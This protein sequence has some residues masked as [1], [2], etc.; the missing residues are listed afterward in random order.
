MRFYFLVISIA[1]LYAVFADH[2]SHDKDGNHKDH[3]HKGHGDHHHHDHHHGKEKHHHHH[4]NHSEES[5]ACHKLSPFNSK[6]AFNLFRQVAAEHPSENIFFSPVS[7]ST[8]FA[9]LSLGAKGATLS[10]IL[11]G[12]SFNASE[13][14]E[15]EIH[16]GFQ[17]LLHM[18]NDPHSEL[19]LES[20]NALFV[21]DDFKPLQKFL[22]DVKKFYESE[23]FST[24][25]KNEEE[26]KKLINDYVEKKTHGKIAELLKSVNPQSVLLLIN[27]IYFRGKW[28]KPFEV[29]FTKDGDFHVDN[30]TVVT[31]PMMS[32][33]GRF[34]VAYDKEHGCTVVE[35]PYKGNAT[36][37]FI[38]PDEGKL[39]QVEEALNKP[40][41]KSWKKLFH[42][43]SIDLKIPKFSIS[44]TLDLK[45]ELTK[46]GV[47]D[48]FS[49]RSDL[50][51]IVESPP[52]KVS[53]A[54]HKAVLSIDEKGTEAA[55]TT[56]IEIMPM[57]LPMRYSFDR[58][59]LVVIYDLETRN[60]LFL[61]RIV[62]PNK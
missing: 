30:E 43:Q 5:M 23:A 54:I 3:D 53:K 41:I 29:E 1:L 24:D 58:P 46:M 26:A 50:S 15:E 33:N 28:E 4:H 36:S 19:Q 17:H 59:F 18:L 52:L 40:T 39:Q 38:L 8:A 16:P 45:E 25:F 6:F 51:G 47:T 11:E 10:Q 60:S 37:L 55:G 48:V 20:G 42:Y 35:I 22:D 57:S 9:M 62:N 32:K 49:D 56:A 61:G 14:S 12:L 44:A 27:Y 21:A 31:V 7:I 2:H 13:I 34:N